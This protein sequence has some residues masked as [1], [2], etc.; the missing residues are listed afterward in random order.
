MEE[1]ALQ[2][3]HTMEV[4]DQQGP[5]IMEVLEQQGPHIMYYLIKD[6]TPCVS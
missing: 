5:H 4:L 2:G 3:P 1:R 6:S